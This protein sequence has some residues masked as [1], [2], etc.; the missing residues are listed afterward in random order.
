MLLCW[1][2]IR[3]YEGIFTCFPGN[4]ASQLLA[5]ESTVSSCIEWAQLSIWNW[6]S[7]F[8]SPT[9]ESYHL[10]CLT[11]FMGMAWMA[12]QWRGITGRMSMSVEEEKHSIDSALATNSKSVRSGMGSSRELL[13]KLA[14]CSKAWRTIKM[15]RKSMVDFARE[16]LGEEQPNVCVSPN[17][18]PLSWC[19]LMLL[20]HA[21]TLSI[22]FVHV[23]LGRNSI[24]AAETSWMGWI[25]CTYCKNYRFELNIR[26]RTY[27]L[28]AIR[29]MAM[30]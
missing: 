7:F 8:S 17:S 11:L 20:L 24:C 25:T 23:Y 6:V 16:L 12:I 3:I 28:S 27:V 19:L 29:K 18:P 10:I 26:R 1:W 5:G 13:F 9:V 21:E 15:P 22:L 2:K 4:H 14:I 30:L